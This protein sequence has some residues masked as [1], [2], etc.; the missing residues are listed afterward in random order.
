MQIFINKAIDTESSYMMLCQ[1]INNNEKVQHSK[2]ARHLYL[3]LVGYKVESSIIDLILILRKRKFMAKY[4][5][6]VKREKNFPF[7]SM[8]EGSKNSKCS[9]IS[10]KDLFQHLIGVYTFIFLFLFVIFLRFCRGVLF[11]SPPIWFAPWIFFVRDCFKIVFHSDNFLF[12]THLI[13]GH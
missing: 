13:S 2:K 4:V 3:R 8:N 10:L 7:S 11:R 9:L 12:R 5:T 6:K 1:I